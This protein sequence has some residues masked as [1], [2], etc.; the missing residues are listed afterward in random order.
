MSSCGT[1]SVVQ[2][3]HGLS[4][5]P[6]PPTAFDPGEVYLAADALLERP[7]V[8]SR[9]DLAVSPAADLRLLI[10]TSTD[11]Y[12][13][14]AVARTARKEETRE[15]VPVAGHLSG[16]RGHHVVVS[17]GVSRTT[18]APIP[19]TWSLTALSQVTPHL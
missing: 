16:G 4:G 5:L 2:I 15:V 8:H 9:V 6:G 11:S 18:I 12:R 14:Q 13:F 1:E 3:D 10:Q 7:V 17:R 19:A